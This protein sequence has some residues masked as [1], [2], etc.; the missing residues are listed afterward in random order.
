MLP[1][2]LCEATSCR[3]DGTWPTW[4]LAEIYTA[5][6]DKDEAF[7]WLEAAY[8]QRN[9]YLPGMG[10]NPFFAP[11]RDDPRFQDSCGG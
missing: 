3:S 11:L 5:L 4:G 7:R 6:G 2:F 10:H 9:G 1:L 8:E